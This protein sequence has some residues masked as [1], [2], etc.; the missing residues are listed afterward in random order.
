MHTHPYRWQKVAAENGSVDA[1][2]AI[3]VAYSSI[4]GDDGRAAPYFQRVAQYVPAMQAQM[5]AFHNG[6]SSNVSISAACY[7]HACWYAEKGSKKKMDLAMEW[8]TYGAQ[9]LANAHHYAASCEALGDYFWLYRIHGRHTTTIVH[10]FEDECDALHWYE[11]GA[12]VTTTTTN[13]TTIPARPSIHCAIRAATMYMEGSLYPTQGFAADHKQA[14]RYHTIAADLGDI[15][16]MMKMAS[17]F[18]GLYHQGWPQLSHLTLDESKVIHWFGRAAHRGDTTA[19]IYW[20]FLLIHQPLLSDD[21]RST[22]LP[23][24]IRSDSSDEGTTSTSTEPSLSPSEQQRSDERQ[25][26]T[27]LQTLESESICS[28]SEVSNILGMYHESGRGGLPRDERRAIEC[29]KDAILLGDAHAHY[30]L[31]RW[32][33]QAEIK[34]ASTG[35]ER[36]LNKALEYLEKA[37]EGNG[38]Y[39]PRRE[40]RQLLITVSNIVNPPINDD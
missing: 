20:A 7:R 10:Q 38:W 3:G 17:Y 32:Y 31:A 1:C 21:K 24:P 23:L 5:A 25:A 16:S 18:G 39:A 6:T 19:R 4:I 29:Y 36:D 12:E 22:P 33:Y 35:I 13:T 26:V 2:Y 14:F 15:T 40:V 27:W 28:S 11:C 37:N 8:W 34:V 30:N 9:F